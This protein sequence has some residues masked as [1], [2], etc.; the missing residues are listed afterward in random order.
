MSSL[1][2]SA[3]LIGMV[4]PGAGFA[5]DP[6]RPGGTLSLAQAMDFALA[7][8]PDIAAAR[9]ELKAREGEALQARLPGNPELGLELENLAARGALAEENQELTASLSQTVDPGRLA[10]AQVAAREQE[11][12]RLELEAGRRRVRA[13]V[14]MH[15]VAVQ[16]GQDRSGLSRELV[17]LAA[18]A[19]GA[20]AEK[21]LAGKAPP[22]D[23]LQSFMAL[24]QARIDSGKASQGLAAARRALARACGMT[25]AAFDSVA[26]RLDLARSVPAWE[27]VSRRIPE[28]PE[29]KRIAFGAK[30]REAEARREKFARIP[31]VTLAAG[32]RQVPDREGRAFVAGLTMP[33]PAW[34]W[35]QGAVRAAESRAR[36]AEAEGEAERLEWVENLAALQAKASDSHREAA[37]LRDQILPA[38]SAAFEGAQEAYRAG[39]FGSLDALNA[40]RAFFAARAQYLEALESS[41]TALAELEESIGWDAAGRAENR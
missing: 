31:P 17:A 16:A 9:H 2:R 26:G 1:L 35:N 22:T 20:A 7:H 40:Q 23:S 3:L 19:H 15:F 5:L 27:E 25:G 34:D 24:S 4:L 12:A 10:R 28:S 37:M 33:L 6:A 8:A 39:K 29:G 36:K 13:R 14:R 11:R 41:H 18:R 30:V 38:A 32:I 21:V